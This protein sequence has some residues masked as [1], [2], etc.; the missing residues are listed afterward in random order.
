MKEYGYLQLNLTL[1]SVE[2]SQ[3]RNIRF[4][5]G[6]T[7]SRPGPFIIADSYQ[8]NCAK[9]TKDKSK[10]S[11]IC[12]Q[13]QTPAVKCRSK[14]VVRFPDGA[15]VVMSMSKH[16][17]KPNKPL[18]IAEYMRDE[19]KSKVRENL[20]SN[21]QE[22]IEEVKIKYANMYK[23]Y[24][25]WR[26]VMENLGMD[27]TI[28]RALHHE[29]SRFFEKEII[30]IFPKSNDSVSIQKPINE[31]ASKGMNAEESFVDTY[32]LNIQKTDREGRFKFFPGRKP[33]SS[34]GILIV[35]DKYKMTCNNA[36]KE[37]Q[38][39]YY[40]CHL[41]PISGVKCPA[42]A[43]VIIS[44]GKPLVN[45]S[46]E[47]S[48]QP[49]Q[50][51]IIAEV[52]RAEIKAKVLKNPLRKLQ[53]SIDEVNIK[54]A[55]KYNEDEEF[56][57]QVIEWFGSP[58]AL[59]RCLQRAL[60]EKHRRNR[61]IVKTGIRHVAPKPDIYT[62]VPGRRKTNPGLLIV[63]DCYQFFYNHIRGNKSLYYRC[64]ESHNPG[65]NCSATAIVK[66]KEG[67]PVLVSYDR[68][69]LCFPNKPKMIANRMK[70]EMKKM[71]LENVTVGN[72]IKTVWKIFEEKYKKDEEVWKQVAR[73]LGKKLF[74]RNLYRHKQFSRSG[75]GYFRERRS[76][77]EDLDLEL[78]IN[79][80]Q[81]NAEDDMAAETNKSNGDLIE[82]DDVGKDLKSEMMN[83][84]EYWENDISEGEEC[85]NGKDFN[86]LQ[87]DLGKS[88]S[89]E[90]EE[91]IGLNKSNLILA[92]DDEDSQN[93]GKDEVRIK[94]EKI[95]DISNFLIDIGLSD[96][97]KK[98]IAEDIDLSL[99]L[100][101]SEKD[102]KELR[103]SLN[104]SLGNMFRIK[105]ELKKYKK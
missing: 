45:L 5:Q 76:E 44:A 15:P 40:L 101:L 75:T 82:Q 56:Y 92:I 20:Y 65:V 102:M 84:S 83:A 63:E 87:E 99:M 1:R 47:H 53:E 85:T 7:E 21:I 57:N 96:F 49:N 90:Q 77:S 59:L 43:Y 50:P 38:S 48:C 41:S 29:K 9:W 19:M 95:P 62:F 58:G 67:N 98:F 64:C 103:T 23:D 54:Y 100:Q 71:V 12:A 86:I 91:I 61:R 78:E 32:D 27:R 4:I 70:A 55:N 46:S 36:R 81:D 18:M 104:I 51:M 17:C 66:I 105:N 2:M 28:E 73:F 42:R 16:N 34:P 93:V 72:A 89:A 31:K 11:Y 52:M 60:G 10:Y 69:H 97:L 30:E 13:H 74:T 68:E 37:V 25:F 26:E 79:G 33:S 24:K 3:A 94:T 22:T 80:V 6:R 14:A 8:M 88:D 39:F 35:D